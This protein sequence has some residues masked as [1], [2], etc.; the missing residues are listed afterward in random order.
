[1]ITKEPSMIFYSSKSNK[2]FLSLDAACKSEARTIIK[3]RHPNER[4]GYDDA[5]CYYE[6]FNWHEIARSDVLYRRLTAKI[7][8]NHMKIL[9]ER[10]K[11]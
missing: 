8:K 9:R 7:K 10:M 4:P 6:G 3:T 5:G 11:C 2:R 1:M